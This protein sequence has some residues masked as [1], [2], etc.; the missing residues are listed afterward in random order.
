MLKIQRC[1]TEINYICNYIKYFYFFKLYSYFPIL[2][3]YGIFDH[4]DE[5]KTFKKF[6]PSDVKFALCSLNIL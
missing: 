1:I 2:L 4:L 5:H 6:F 3:F